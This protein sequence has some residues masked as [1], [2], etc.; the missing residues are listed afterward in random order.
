[1]TKINSR[2]RIN[3]NVLALPSP[4]VVYSPAAGEFFLQSGTFYQSF[5]EYDVYGGDSSGNVFHAQENG[6]ILAY[7]IDENG[8]V[9]EDINN[10]LHIGRQGEKISQFHE[11]VMLACRTEFP[12]QIPRL[13]SGIKKKLAGYGIGVLDDKKE[14][15]EMSVELIRLAG[16]GYLF[17]TGE[18]YP[19]YL[20]FRHEYAA[21]E[22]SD[23]LL[24]KDI[25]VTLKALFSVLPAPGKLIL[26]VDGNDGGRYNLN[27]VRL[28]NDAR[29]FD[30]EI[31]CPN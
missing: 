31:V 8:H 6:E 11:A 10:C 23:E 20:P 25:T 28:L 17:T 26:K 15:L 29:E 13:I 4:R 24:A 14:C 5:G 2:T 30:F 16:D 27:V 21:E 1:M 19:C 7:P 9:H 3:S 12:E 22:Y 18:S